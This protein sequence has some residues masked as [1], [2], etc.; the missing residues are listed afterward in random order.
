[1]RQLCQRTGKAKRSR[2]PRPCMYPQDNPAMLRQKPPVA[3]GT[4]QAMP[5]SSPAVPTAAD[6]AFPASLPV[7]H[8]CA[9]LPAGLCHTQKAQERGRVMQ[10]AAGFAI[11]GL[12]CSY[13]VPCGGAAVEKG[14]GTPEQG[15]IDFPPRPF[16]PRP[17]ACHSHIDPVNIKNINVNNQA[18]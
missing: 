16:S 5:A 1:M 13:S 3:R 14:Y 4:E 10:P 7:G 12:N 9:S 17:S 2:I 15:R 8:P 6:S 18:L 11:V